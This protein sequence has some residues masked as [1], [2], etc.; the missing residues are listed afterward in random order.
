MPN[1]VLTLEELAAIVFEEKPY[2]L[3]VEQKKR[4]NA[5]FDFLKSF[6]V[7]KVIYGINTGFGPMAQYKISE[8]DLSRL[9]Y[10]LVR[11]HASGTGEP[12]NEK[13]TR[14][15]MTCRL[16]SLA[17]GYSGVSPAVTEQLEKFLEHELYPVIFSHGGVGA[18]G[19]LVQLSHLALGLIGEGDAFHQGQRQP[20]SKILKK[21][22]LSPL[23]LS[24]RDGL[25]IINGTS[26]MTGL[27]AL[28]VLASEKLLRWAVAASCLINEIIAA[29]DD[30]FSEALNRSKQH[31]GQR[32]VAA[33]MR[34][35]LEDSRLINKRES[36]FFTD[37]EE[38]G[39][40]VFRKKLQEYYSIRC[41]PQILGPVWDAVQAAR[42][43]T[44]NEINSASDNPIVDMENKTN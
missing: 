8:T 38:S 17:L 36:W 33:M 3:S 18:S 4:V 44:Q 37:T 31:P 27:A 35:H 9:Q 40:Q 15:V 14:A 22:K 1:R 6:S 26:C 12:L 10:N 41:I 34:E 24:L 20:V 5:S 28:N 7:N 19:D 39:R 23:Q 30:A 16:H 32:N 13:E 21:L 42:Q 43:L 25:A 2:R 29:F 11:S